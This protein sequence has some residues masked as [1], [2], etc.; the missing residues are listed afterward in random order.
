[1][2]S[3]PFAVQELNSKFYVCWSGS[4]AENFIKKNDIFNILRKVSRYHEIGFAIKFNNGEYDV[5]WIDTELLYQKNNYLEYMRD[6]Y[7]ILGMVFHTEVEAQRFSE[8]LDKKFMW[9]VL[10][11][12]VV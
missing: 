5:F 9:G 12:S 1:M 3:S 7:I 11:G 10:D 8:E 4:T 6:M 2:S